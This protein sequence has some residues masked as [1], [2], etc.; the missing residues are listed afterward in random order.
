MGPDAVGLDGKEPDAIELDIEEPDA[1]EPHA[2][3]E[4]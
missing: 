3:P 4:V 2:G 1:V